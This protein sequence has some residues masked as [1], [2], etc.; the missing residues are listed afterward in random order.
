MNSHAAGAACAGVLTALA[1]VAADLVA[2]RAAA[3]VEQ[4]GAS[5]KLVAALADNAGHGLIATVAWAGA[6]LIEATPGEIWAALQRPSPS[7]LPPLSLRAALLCGLVSCALDADHFIAASSWTLE[8]ALTLHSRPFGHA[9]AFVGAACAGTWLVVGKA[10]PFFLLAGG[11]SSSSAA[12]LPHPL[13]FLPL[14]VLVALLSHQLR[15]AT[16]RGLWLWPWGYSTPP[17][18]QPLYLG[19]LMLFPVVAW[20]LLGPH[21]GPCGGGKGGGDESLAGGGLPGGGGGGLGD[22]CGR[23]MAK[24]LALLSSRGG[25]PGDGGWA[26]P[27]RAR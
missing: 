5:S 11:P 19:S 26:G 3:G 18:P 17:I 14:L 22:R 25:P 24:S 7:L 13:S 8:G 12:V 21:L 16:R 23:S 20:V 10:L 6:L 4:R 15:D 2:S 9:L 1:A 27:W